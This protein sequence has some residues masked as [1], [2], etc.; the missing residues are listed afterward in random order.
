MY[1]KGVT[2]LGPHTRP[3]CYQAL[4]EI[5]SLK[6]CEKCG[7]NYCVSVF[8]FPWGHVNSYDHILALTRQIGHVCSMLDSDWLKKSCCALIG[9]DLLG[10]L[11]LLTF[12][13]KL[14][15]SISPFRWA[16]VQFTTIKYDK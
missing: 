16:F 5:C 6:L 13:R 11:L 9:R 10:P 3:A 4:L 12:E 7:S 15:T 14:D 2:S 1:V 8:F